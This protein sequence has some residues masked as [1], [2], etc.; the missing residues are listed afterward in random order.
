MKVMP[1]SAE[2]RLELLVGHLADMLHP[3]RELVATLRLRAN[4]SAITR[5]ELE[6][7][8]D[9]AGTTWQSLGQIRTEAKSIRREIAKGQ[10]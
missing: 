4:A 7:L 2:A 3:A 5:G 1:V 10:P 9:L 8:T 6:H